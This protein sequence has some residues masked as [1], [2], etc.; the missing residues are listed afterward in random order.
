MRSGGKQE[1][2]NLPL[3]KIMPEIAKGR[4]SD[5]WDGARMAEDRVV[6]LSND[7]SD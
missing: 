4:E 6:K 5:W 1:R 3:G 2:K 7:D